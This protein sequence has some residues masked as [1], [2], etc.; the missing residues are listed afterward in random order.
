[1]NARQKAKKYKKLA[2]INREK[3]QAY[4][5]LMLVNAFENSARLICTTEIKP[6]RCEYML[7]ISEALLDCRE[8]AEYKL[9]AEIVNLISTNMKIKVTDVEYGKKYET[10]FYLGFVDL[11]EERNDI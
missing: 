11:D 9:C 10:K 1:M 5:R 3:A 8:M 4:D 6:Y 7:P 2:D